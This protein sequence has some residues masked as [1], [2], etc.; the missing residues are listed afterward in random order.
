MYADRHNRPT[1]LDPRS[2]GIA[3]AING[4][5]VA[6]LIAS[7]PVMDIIKPPR[8]PIQVVDVPIQPLPAEV[9]PPP[10]SAERRQARSRA[11]DAPKPLVDVPPTTNTVDTTDLVAPRPLPSASGTVAVSDATPTPAL[12]TI[13]PEIDADHRG[14][15]Q[16]TYP[17][18][19]LRAE[20]VGVV[21]VGVLVGVDGRVR[22]VEPVRATSDAFFRATQDQALRRWR[23]RPATRGSVP[24]EAWRQMTI[25]FV[26]PR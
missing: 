4:A 8:P 7:Q 5:V 10:K 14:D 25:R 17:A 22:Q 2:L 26:I 15:L 24:V 9:P 20:R 12:V 23:F 19:E 3:V 21:V 16:P 13:P 1:G 18:A 6:A 11:V